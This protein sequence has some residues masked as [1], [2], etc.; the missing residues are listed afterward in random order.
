MCNYIEICICYTLSHVKK[1][2]SNSDTSILL[3]LSLEETTLTVGDSFGELSILPP[4]LHK[5]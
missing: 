1:Q 3:L 5:I 4:A 2:G